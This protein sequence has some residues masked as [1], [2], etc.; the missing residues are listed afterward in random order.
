MCE[1]LDAADSPSLSMPTPCRGTK[2]RAASRD[3]DWPPVVTDAGNADDG[4]LSDVGPDQLGVKRRRLRCKQSVVADETI[5]SLLDASVVT[6]RSVQ[7]R[8]NVNGDRTTNRARGNT[9]VDPGG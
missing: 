6:D 8:S 5:A 1:L 9:F 4:L 7:D 3:V 2:R